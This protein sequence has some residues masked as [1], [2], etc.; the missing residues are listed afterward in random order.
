MNYEILNLMAAPGSVTDTSAA[1]LWDKLEDAGAVEEYEVLVDGKVYGRSVHTDMTIE[2]LESG[3]SYEMWVRARGKDG[4]S[5]AQSGRISIA[6]RK[7]PEVFDVTAYGASGDGSTLNTAAIQAAIDACSPGG[8]VVIP[9]GIFLSG[10]VF[11]KSD[12]TLYLEEGAVLLGSVHPWDYPVMEYR[13][14]GR[15]CLCYAGLINTK[16]LDGARLHDITIAGPGKIDASGEALRRAQLA[17]G[18]GIKGRALVL[19][20]VDRIYLKDITVKQSP[21]WCVHLIYSS[22]ISINNVKVYTKCDEDGRKYHDINN[23][24]GIDPDSCRNVYIFHC[25]IASQDD[26]IAIKSGKD[27]DGRRVGIPSENI[28]ITNCSFRS[29]FGVAVGSEMSGGVRNVLVQ[30]CSFENVYSVGSVKTPRGRGSIVENITYE[31]CFFRNYSTE[32]EDCKWFRGA[33]YIDQFYSHEEVAEG[34]AEP[35]TEE[36]PRIRS[37]TFRNIDAET[38]AGN[39]IYIVGLPEMPLE[40]IRLENIRAKG[41]FGM[42]INNVKG[43]IME[44]VSVEGV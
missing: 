34:A 22:D 38:V 37:I 8:R 35:V 41:R 28:R 6:T 16:T 11:L 1:L 19:R 14:E 9:K 43:L 23:G 3:R 2:G 5:A 13:W 40:N 33:I 26:C 44:K 15:E 27:E 4:S 29:G 42:K 21:A 36:T 31:D 12:M 20:N 17:E 32:H 7:A 24:D 18:A 39:A 10:A 25:M 30:D